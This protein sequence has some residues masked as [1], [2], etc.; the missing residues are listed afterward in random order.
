MKETKI[1]IYGHEGN[2]MMIILSIILL[3]GGIYLITSS[4]SPSKRSASNIHTLPE[5]QPSIVSNQEP[6]DTSKTELPLVK[7]DE[8]VWK[9]KNGVYVND[10]QGLSKIE[11]VDP[12]TFVAV[13]DEYYKDNSRVFYLRHSTDGD[14][15]VPVD[16]LD[17]ETF[18]PFNSIY[19]KDKNGV[20][21]FRGDLHSKGDLVLMQFA[22]PYTFSVDKFYS[23]LARD[24]KYVYWLGVDIVFEGEDPRVVGADAATFVAVE[25]GSNL[26]KDKNHVY[27]G[28][29]F[30]TKGQT[31]MSILVGVE[32][33]K[34]T[35]F[36]PVPNTENYPPSYS[37]G[38]AYGTDG[39]YVFYYNHKIEGADPT[40]FKLFKTNSDVYPTYD[41]KDDSHIYYEGR[42]IQ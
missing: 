34:F 23:G 9:D 27:S 2:L 17:S 31:P 15:L 10:G 42:L 29:N 32:P 13:L 24:S 25:N 16:K 22:D 5:T 40:S 8:F 7:I 20:Y 21:F 37:R 30:Y 19:V 41:A 39:Q 4:K 14:S 12:V 35:A 28:Y 33:K 18:S 1:R 11:G 6:M 26:F 3:V 36:G 38:S